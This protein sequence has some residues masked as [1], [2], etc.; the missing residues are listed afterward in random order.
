MDEPIRMKNNG[1]I[2]IMLNVD[3][4]GKVTDQLSRSVLSKPLAHEHKVLKEIER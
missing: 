4:R 3:Q 2:S 1:Q